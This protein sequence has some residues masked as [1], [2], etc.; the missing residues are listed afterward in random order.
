MESEK[1][2]TGFGSRQEKRRFIRLNLDP[3]LPVKFKFVSSSH[4]SMSISQ[5]KEAF[6]KNISIGGGFIIELVINR[7]E[8]QDC[9]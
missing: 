1:N 6:I 3:P 9:L 2:S 4:V 7:K 8:E 5:E